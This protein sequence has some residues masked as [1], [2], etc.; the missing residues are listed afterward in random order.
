[1]KKNWFGR[2]MSRKVSK[3]QCDIHVVVKQGELLSCGS[4]KGTDL[5]KKGDNY[6]VC[7]YCGNTMT[8]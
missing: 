7:N 1:M 2:I 3:K 6:Y 5:R 8:T 4:C